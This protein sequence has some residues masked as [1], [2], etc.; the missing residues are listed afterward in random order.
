M[1]DGAL[2]VRGGRNGLA[3][4]DEPFLLQGPVNLIA[5]THALL[6]VSFPLP[7]RGDIREAA[8]RA[9]DPILFADRRAR[10]VHCEVRSIATPKDL[11]GYVADLPS[12]RAIHRAL[13]DPID[14]AVLM[15][16]MHEG[17]GVLAD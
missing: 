2:G 7:S 11:C 9:D 14:A 1:P 15:G 8:D 13:F 16:M 10:V 5:K 3:V 4:Q 6:E 17:V 12:Q